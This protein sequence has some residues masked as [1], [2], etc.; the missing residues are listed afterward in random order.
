MSASS[1]ASSAL[2]SPLTPLAAYSE[3]VSEEGSLNGGEQ[4]QDPDPAPRSKVP[5]PIDTASSTL[6][7]PIEALGFQ[8]AQEQALPEQ[9]PSKL[10]F[11][12]TGTTEGTPG[13]STANIRKGKG[14][15]KRKATDSP[16]GHGKS[17]TGPKEVS[18]ESPAL[19]EI[20]PPLRYSYSGKSKVPDKYPGTLYASEKD[21]YGH[22]RDLRNYLTIHG[23]NPKQSESIWYLSLSREIRPQVEA[24]V[25]G[26]IRW[27]K[28]EKVMKNLFARSGAQENVDIAEMAAKTYFKSFHTTI[29]YIECLN[30]RMLP[31][32]TK[33]DPV[34]YKKAKTVFLDALRF[35]GEYEID[36]QELIRKWESGEQAPPL[37]FL[38]V[39]KPY[40]LFDQIVSY[41]TSEASKVKKKRKREEE[42][43]GE[44]KAKK[45]KKDKKEKEPRKE[46]EKPVE[47]QPKAKE[48]KIPINCKFW[49]RYGNCKYGDNCRYKHPAKKDQQ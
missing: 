32:T 26:S 17:G 1:S 29:S 37:P 38:T 14:S 34:S 4:R 12:E 48:S 44:F 35:R 31:Y 11:P 42:S 19:M 3:L 25:G 41:F 40:D 22:L 8:R 49:V 5:P 30:N 36:L 21:V 6:T 10:F 27:E 13:R 39:T 28:F 46:K 7:A 33:G 45:G 47:L 2:S 20:D 43:F 24:L 18:P 16:P 9:G 23:F 15:G